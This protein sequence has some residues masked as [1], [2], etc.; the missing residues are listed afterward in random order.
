MYSDPISS[1][2]PAA[3]GIDNPGCVQW[4]ETLPAQEESAGRDIPMEQLVT[5]VLVSRESPLPPCQ[6]WPGRNSPV[7]R[8]WEPGPERCPHPCVDCGWM[9]VVR[10]PRKK[11]IVAFAADEPDSSEPAKGLK[12]GVFQMWG[13]G[14][15]YREEEDGCREG[16]GKGWCLFIHC[17]LFDSRSFSHFL[18]LRYQIMCWPGPLPKG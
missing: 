6:H 1:T 8:H 12:K 17:L 4:R 18:F 10:T 14:C 16:G 5:K 3:A 9:S 11:K 2:T 15:V 13:E 7:P